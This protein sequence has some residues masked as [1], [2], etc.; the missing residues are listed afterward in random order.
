MT[1]RQTNI[2]TETERLADRK[3]E[4]KAKIQHNNNYVMQED[5]L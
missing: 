5:E 3:I 4:R 2:Q 1:I